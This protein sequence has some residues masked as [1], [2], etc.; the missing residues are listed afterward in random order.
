MIKRNW[1]DGKKLDKKYGGYHY[2]YMSKRWK[3]RRL[4]QLMQHP[5]CTACMAENHVKAA[6]IVH[7][8]I[9]HRGDEYLFYHS[10]VI[11]LCKKCHDNVREGSKYLSY[12][13]GCD[14]HGKPYKTKPIFIDH[15]KKAAGGLDFV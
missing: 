7:H 10:P 13:R 15:N 8:T 5:L 3:M 4:H 2:L 14:I 11:S 6:T 12:Q 1:A 9:D